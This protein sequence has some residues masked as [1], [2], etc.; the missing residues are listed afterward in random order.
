[1]S[2]NRPSDHSAQHDVWIDNS[3]YPLIV[4]MIAQ[5]CDGPTQAAFSATTKARRARLA[6]LLHHANVVSD[7]NGGAELV[8]AGTVARRETDPACLPL[9]PHMIHIL[10]LD[11][12]YWDDYVQGI[13]GAPSPTFPT[14]GLTSLRLLRRMGSAAGLHRSNTGRRFATLPR[15]PTLVD[16]IDINGTSFLSEQDNARIELQACLDRYILHLRWDATRPLPPKFDDIRFNRRGTVRQVFVVLHPHSGRTGEVVSAK[17]AAT[18]VGHFLKSYF[19]PYP[20]HVPPTTFH[21]IGLEQTDI[22]PLVNIDCMPG[23]NHDSCAC[24]HVSMRLYLTFVDVMLEAYTTALRGVALGDIPQNTEIELDITYDTQDRWREGIGADEAVV[25]HWVHPRGDAKTLDHT[26]YPYIIDLI[27]HRCDAPTQAAFSATAKAY[28]TRLAKLVQHVNA[29]YDDGQV[30]FDYP[31]ATTP[32]LTD[33][34]HLPFIAPLVRTLDLDDA[35]WYNNYVADPEAE[36]NG[37]GVKRTVSS[38]T[39][40]LLVVVRRMGSAVGVPNDFIRRHFPNIPKAKS[41][42]DYVDVNGTSRIWDSNDENGPLIDLSFIKDMYILHLRWDVSTPMPARLSNVRFTDCSHV[43]CMLFVLHPHST[44]P[45]YQDWQES[46]A[47]L[48]A[49]VF[50][51]LYQAIHNEA[52]PKRL[53]FIIIGLE[54][55]DPKWRNRSPA[56]RC[57]EDYS[58]QY[59]PFVSLL[60]HAWDILPIPPHC[61]R[62]LYFKFGSLAQFHAVL[63]KDKVLAGQWVQPHEEAKTVRR[64]RFH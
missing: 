23:C 24:Q 34:L 27:L 56:S 21:L 9:V 29:I 62:D 30:R 5:H 10:D 59:Q 13:Q 20:H 55:T 8:C 37:S 48:L 19:F 25:G 11:D 58:A 47:N 18:V 7:G 64:T 32:R 12:G 41:L 43:K 52:N 45:D 44:L 6:E 14:G 33:P 63:P 54:Q 26:A 4:D 1:M 49:L 51:S 53:E 3:G 2:P 31:R 35:M 28:R 39:P 38:S 17:S 61:G 42:V 46:A 36:Y 60:R 16:Y 22:G 50:S 57:D 15:V 40:P